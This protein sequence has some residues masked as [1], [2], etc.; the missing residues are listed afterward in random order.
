MKVLFICNKS[1]YPPN[2]GGS[3]GMYVFI[4]GIA[5]AGH[6]VKVLALNTNKSYISYQDIPEEF[7]KQTRIELIDKDLSLNPLAAFLNLFSRKSYHVERFISKEFEVKIT[8]VLKKETFDIV[9]VEYLYMAP[10]LKVIRK[11]SKA[12]VIL[13]SHNIEHMIWARITSISGN[14]LK[15]LYL[16]ILTRRLKNYE[17][18]VLQD[19]DGVTTVS[20][21]DAEFFV[22]SGIHVPVIDIPFGI[23]IDKYDFKKN[24]YEFPSLFHLGAMNWI[25]NQEGIKWFLDHAWP[26]IHEKYPN[27]KF[28]LAGRMMP[29]WLLNTVQPN[30]EIL[31][32]V[33]DATEF[34][35]SKAVMIVPLFSGSG[36]R[37]KIIEGMALGKT[38]ISTGIGAEGIEFTDH[39]NILIANTPEE[40]V[41]AVGFCIN[42]RDLCDQIGKNAREL[43][44]LNHSLRNI[45]RKLED[46]YTSVMKN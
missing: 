1:P 19:F 7:R 17:L 35:N 8:E 29:D 13:R 43:I 36:I 4:K 31:G 11:F 2:E 18:S 9:Q 44:E 15:K 32:E 37:V 24:S 38:V 21:I 20:K 6:Q 46:F 30:V 10:Y 42:D 3:L 23:D 26:L 28:Y 22:R 25:P 27:L 40:F 5:E 12:K 45:I 14:P 34:I 39:K 41:K 16:G 33:A